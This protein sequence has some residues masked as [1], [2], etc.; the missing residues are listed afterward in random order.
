MEVPVRGRFLGD[1]LVLSGPGTENEGAMNR[2]WIV[3]P[4]VVLLTGMASGHATDPPPQEPPGG[5][6]L[7]AWVRQLR[8]ADARGRRQA[9]RALGR[10]GPGAAA[11]VP[12]L[13]QAFRRNDPGRPPGARQSPGVDRPSRRPGADSSTAGQGSESPGRGRGGAGRGRP[14]GRPRTDRGDRRPAA[15]P[16]A[17]GRHGPR[18]PWP[19]GRGGRPRL[20]SHAPRSGLQH[21]EPGRRGPEFDRP[22]R[23]PRP[24]RG[25]KGAGSGS[26]A[27]RPPMPFPGSAGRMRPF[28]P[29]PRCYGTGP[30]PTWRLAAATALSGIGPTCV[31]ALVEALKDPSPAVRADAAYGLTHLSFAARAAVPALAV[32][33]RDEDAQVRERASEALGSIG[34]AAVPALIAATPGRAARRP[35]TGRRSTEP[36]RPRGCGPPSRPSWHRFEIGT[37]WSGCGPPRPSGGL[38]GTRRSPRPGRSPARRA[39]GRPPRGRPDTD[40]DRPRGAGGRPRPHRGAPRR[41]PRGPRGVPFCPGAD[42]PRGA[43]GRPRP[44]RHAGGS[45]APGIYPFR[46]CGHQAP[47]PLLLPRSPASW[48]T[49]DRGRGPPPPP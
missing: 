21:A 35:P 25:G 40:R 13:I 18:T 33:L 29:W 11:A 39:T 10:I 24:G 43:G 47:P 17:T 16:P 14:A 26:S 45:A 1:I 41:G 4:V 3:G 8:D 12:V 6:P 9:A 38:P 30:T 46:R 19:R 48:A 2:H 27:S 20:G 49:S 5:R 28:P 7:D 31:P 23:R 15:R 32:A 37:A 44:H 22:S 42:W 36:N 34:P